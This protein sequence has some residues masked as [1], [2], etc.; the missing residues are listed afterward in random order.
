MA[1]LR[2][3]TRPAEAAS[4]GDLA[5]TFAAY[6]D[7]LS[8]LDEADVAEACRK[9]PRIAGRGQW[10]PA[11]AELRE[12]ATDIGADRQRA[13]ERRLLA[14]PSLIEDVSRWPVQLFWLQRRLVAD[15]GQ[16]DGIDRVKALARTVGVEAVVQACAAEDWARH[17]TLGAAERVFARFGWTRQDGPTLRVVA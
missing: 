13:S 15:G 11:L 4:E 1:R 2:V 14:D 10:W 7:G 16:R 9:W 12:L 3:S 8:D 17:Q 6:L 5:L